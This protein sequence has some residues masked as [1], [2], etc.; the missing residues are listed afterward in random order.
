MKTMGAAK[1]K[2]QCLAV[3]AEVQ[4]R[5]EPVLVTKNGKPMVKMVPLD[6]AEDI[7]PLDAF[8]FPGVTIAGDVMSPL[9]SDE[10]Y[11]E[12]YQRS[13]E[14]LHDTSR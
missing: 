12:F 4:A 3:I 10:E 9:Y 5:R 8:H 13:V 1:F 2:A 11:E 7:D 6:L 14:Q